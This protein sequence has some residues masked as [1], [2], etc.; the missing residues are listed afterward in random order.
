MLYCTI[1]HYIIYSIILYYI[2]YYIILYCIIS[3]YIVYYIIYSIILYYIL[4]YTLSAHAV[5]GATLFAWRRCAP[6]ARGCISDPSRC[7]PPG[8]CGWA[9]PNK[10]DTS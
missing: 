7:T 2:F 9:T 3:Y 6:S 5:S 8:G 10:W 1:L 4:Y